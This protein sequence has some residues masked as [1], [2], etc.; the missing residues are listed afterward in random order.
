[1]DNSVLVNITWNPENNI[2]LSSS[3]GFPKIW[4]RTPDLVFNKWLEQQG[5]DQAMA[6]FISTNNL[7]TIEQP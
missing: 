4:T 6:Y 7:F 3:L 1:M 2:N 5:Y